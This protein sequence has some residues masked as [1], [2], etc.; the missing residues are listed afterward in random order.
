M[1]KNSILAVVALVAFTGIYAQE[2]QRQE[3]QPYFENF[4]DALAASDEGEKIPATE[5]Q[6]KEIFRVNQ[7]H[8]VKRSKKTTISE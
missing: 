7:N 3:S 4:K 1:K 2:D 5:T 8:L 6:E